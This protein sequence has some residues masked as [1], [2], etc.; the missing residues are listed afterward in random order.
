MDDSIEDKYKQ[1]INSQICETGAYFQCTPFTHKF[2]TLSLPF[3]NSEAK[4][5]TSSES[6][7]SIF[8]HTTI[9]FCIIIL[10]SSESNSCPKY[11]E[12]KLTCVFNNGERN[13]FGWFT[14]DW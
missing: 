11:F 14:L 8:F 3:N 2:E 13:R 6:E 1:V 12:Y 7:N 9:P 5:L 4:P 10:Y